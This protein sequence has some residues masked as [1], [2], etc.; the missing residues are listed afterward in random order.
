MSNKK[1]N[2]E[3]YNVAAERLGLANDVCVVIE[4]SIVGLRAAKGAGMKC[5]ITYTPE[6]ANEDFYGGGADAKL[7]DF[8]SGVSA[9]DVFAEGPAVGDEL[10]PAVRDP[11]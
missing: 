4:D 2:P 5:I 6:T 1:P 3:I 9:T 11:K 7:L 8:S 10:L